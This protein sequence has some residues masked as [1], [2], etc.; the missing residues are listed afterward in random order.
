MA[1]HEENSRFISQYEISGTKTYGAL[2]RALLAHRSEL[3]VA[4]AVRQ[5][6]QAAIA[7]PIH[8]AAAASGPTSMVG[9][10]LSKPHKYCWTHGV[11]FHDGK[12]CKHKK[13][14]HKEKAT[15]KNRMGG[16]NNKAMPRLIEA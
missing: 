5:M 16:S 10:Q 1:T 15:E 14:G 6:H 13:D 11:T 8:T 3:A 12:E 9:Y 4:N 7:A 2:A